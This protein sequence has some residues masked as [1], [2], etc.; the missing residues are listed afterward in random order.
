MIQG[1]LLTVRKVLS[2]HLY[3]N[4]YAVPPRDHTGALLTPQT[5]MNASSF[6]KVQKGEKWN[7]ALHLEHQRSQPAAN[8]WKRPLNR[9]YLSREASVRPAHTAPQGPHN[10]PATQP[11]SCQP[12]KTWKQPSVHLTIHSPASGS[13]ICD[14]TRVGE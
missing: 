5:A 6:N 10:R 3:Q 14:Q 8:R 1:K 13:L 7:K 12:T 4:Q 2:N 11:C 9:S